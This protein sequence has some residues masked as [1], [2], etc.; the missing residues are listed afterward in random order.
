MK[1]RQIMLEI[2][3]GNFQRID[4]CIDEAPKFDNG[5]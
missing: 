1:E 5:K 2:L 4:K 3:Y